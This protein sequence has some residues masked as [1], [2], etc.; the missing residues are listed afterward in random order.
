[1][2]V[3]TLIVYRH[4]AVIGA[5]ATI[6]TLALEPFVQNTLSYYSKGVQDLEISAQLPRAVNY[7]SDCA[8]CLDLDIGIKSSIIAGYSASPGFNVPN[9]FCASGNCTWTGTSTLGICSR[10]ADISDRL[11]K[12][13]AQLNATT[14]PGLLDN[15]T[16]TL[17][18]GFSLG[19]AVTPS[20]DALANVTALSDSID[21]Y[22]PMV[23]GKYKR[24]L[25]LMWSIFPDSADLDNYYQPIRSSTRMYATECAL[26]PCVQVYDSSLDSSTD[27]MAN[28][29][30]ASF[31][32]IVRAEDD[33]YE[34]R[35]EKLYTEGSVPKY[36]G[37]WFNTT[38]GLFGNDSYHMGEELL[39]PLR[40]YLAQTVT[41]YMTTT[42]DNGNLSPSFASGMNDSTDSLFLQSIFTMDPIDICD[43]NEHKPLPDG[44][45]PDS[46]RFTCAIENIAR[47]MTV[48]IRNKA[49]QATGEQLG[50]RNSSDESKVHFAQSPLIDSSG[51]T[52]VSKTHIS[53]TWGWLTIPAVLWILALVTFLGMIFKTRQNGVRTWRTSVLAPLFIGVEHD[54]VEANEGQ[55]QPL[56]SDG[57]KKKAQRLR[58]RLVTTD[59]DISFVSVPAHD[60]LLKDS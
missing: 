19:S 10:C 44:T 38:A 42:G 15:C 13:C 20:W 5:I 34:Y 48:E 59:R 31:H 30:T 39:Y 1:M 23:Y 2:D 41:G 16:F 8:Y 47:A 32:D 7:T 40:Y 6:L 54:D 12:S 24:P 33:S 53:V 37:A 9:Y 60:G 11:E 27:I 43:P 28:G 21:N 36:A 18:N 55:Y 57:L 26:I 22:D 58:V 52:I 17:P 46:L 35:Y 45:L 49:L 50:P 14:V 3:E 4:F 29:V 25:S 56:T 51:T